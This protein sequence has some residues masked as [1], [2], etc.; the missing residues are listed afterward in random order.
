MSWVVV[1]VAGVGLLKAETVDKDKEDRQRKLA[2]ETQRL[3][4]WTGNK[5]GEIKEADP[6]G[7]ALQYGATGAQLQQ[8]YQNSQANQKLANAQA[9]WLNAGGSPQYTSQVGQSNPYMGW[10]SRGP[11][12]GNDYNQSPSSFFGVSSF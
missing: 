8:G 3:S 7:S 10:G 1:G 9:N 11:I 2:A 6:I 5:A 4:P 12:S